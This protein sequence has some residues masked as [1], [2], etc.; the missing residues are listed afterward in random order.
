M[1]KLFSALALLAC[2][3]FSGCGAETAHAD[4]AATTAPVAQMVQAITNRS[5]LHIE[6]LVTESVSCLHDY[7]LSVRQMQVVESANVIVISGLG[8][9]EFMQDTL[10]GASCVI[11]ASL[12]I[13]QL[14]EDAHIWLDPARAAQM[15]RTIAKELSAIYPQYAD[16]F[17]ENAEAYCK[18]FEALQVYGEQT[19]RDLSCRSLVTFHDGFLYFADAFDL[20]VAAA[21]EVEAG[22][23]PSAGELLDII[24]LVRSEGIPAVFTEENGTTDAASLV[25]SETGAAVFALDLAMGQTDHLS[26][27]KHN[28]DTVKEALR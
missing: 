22:S 17:A 21:M 9:E 10:T 20:S 15:T 18:E 16:I 7:T 28:I 26:A 27:I 19:L 8:T 1:K 14:E 13:T 5:E 12:G 3:L 25:A 23:E 4:I 24:E 11:D 6:P 2:L